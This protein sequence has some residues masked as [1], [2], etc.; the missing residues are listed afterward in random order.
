MPVLSAL[1]ASGAGSGD[2]DGDAVFDTGAG[3]SLE[4]EFASGGAAT[5]APSESSSA[6]IH[7]EVPLP[8]TGKNPFC[9]GPSIERDMPEGSTV[10]TAVSALGPDRRFASVVVAPRAPVAGTAP[11]AA[12]AA[13]GSADTGGAAAITGAASG[14]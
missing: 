9:A 4:R 1:D 6:A 10:R 8:V 7:P 14:A 12:G 2:V 13:T 5:A 3:T 11:A